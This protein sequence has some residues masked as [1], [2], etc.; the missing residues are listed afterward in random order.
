MLF[1]SCVLP[2]FELRFPLL[3]YCAIPACLLDLWASVLNIPFPLLAF[4][5]NIELRLFVAPSFGCDFW[6]K[7]QDVPNVILPFGAIK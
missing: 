3:T 4:K 1:L 5:H 6:V 7:Y 2:F